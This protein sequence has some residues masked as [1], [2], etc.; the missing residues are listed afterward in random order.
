M[1]I[2]KNKSYTIIQVIYKTFYNHF[3][4]TEDRLQ[5]FFFSDED[6]FKSSF[7]RIIR[8]LL[9]TGKTYENCEIN[10]YFELNSMRK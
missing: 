3:A 7:S 8:M 10:C 2:E 6:F 5:N 9:G 4:S 1:F